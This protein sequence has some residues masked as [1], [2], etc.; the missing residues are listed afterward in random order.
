[1]VNRRGADPITTARAKMAECRRVDSAYIVPSLTVTGTPVW[2]PVAVS[3][4]SHRLDRA[5]APLGAS[6]VM[7]WLPALESNQPPTR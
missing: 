2:R 7:K 6:R 3:R 5:A 1:M 4:R